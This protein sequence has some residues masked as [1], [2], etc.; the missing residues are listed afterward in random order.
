MVGQSTE[1]ILV[2]LMGILRIDNQCHEST[3]IN[4]KE[5]DAAHPEE[6][7]QISDQGVDDTDS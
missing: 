4:P 2:R 3:A 7:M 1:N 5:K 6:T